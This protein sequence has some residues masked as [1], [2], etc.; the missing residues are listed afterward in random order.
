METKLHAEIEIFLRGLEEKVNEKMNEKMNEKTNEK[1]NKK[2]NEK[3]NQI[4]NEKMNKNSGV[5]EKINENSGIVDVVESLQFAVVNIIFNILLGKRFDHEDE[6]Y[7]KFRIL[8]NENFRLLGKTLPLNHF[9]FLRRLIPGGLGFWKMMENLKIVDE[10]L[11]KLISEHFNEIVKRNEFEKEAE[12]FCAA[13]LI[14]ME[15]LK[16]TEKNEQNQQMF[17]YDQLRA[18]IRKFFS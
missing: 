8:I 9:P 12:D 16:K 18:I 15:K 5:V 7:K 6:E 11:L 17:N 3:T 13:Y 10:F 1:M 4:V 2:M 14:E